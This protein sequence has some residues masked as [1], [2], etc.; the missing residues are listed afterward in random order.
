MSAAVVVKRGSDRFNKVRKLAGGSP[1]TVKVA[2][3]D[4]NG[5]LLIIEHMHLVKGG[6]PRHLH[7][8]QDE[9][10]YVLDGEYI[11]EVGESRFT[12]GA[13]DCLL[14]PRQVP[15]VWAWVGDVPG[16]L[17]L[18]FQP[19]GQMEAHFELMEQRAGY[20]LDE[21]IAHAHGIIRVG[22]PLSVE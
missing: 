18:V 22:P 4:T 1:L 15:H 20:V 9:W 11:F 2:T 21:K 19:A 7:P 6:P 12:L 5:G 10:F 16:K 13:G 14:G 3:P 8:D 17:L